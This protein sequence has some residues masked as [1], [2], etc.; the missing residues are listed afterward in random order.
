M[1]PNT[2]KYLL[3]VERVCVWKVCKA[4][5][6]GLEV[7]AKVAKAGRGH[8]D[9]WVLIR[10][11]IVRAPLVSRKG[12]ILLFRGLWDLYRQTGR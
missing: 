11:K 12:A 9:F 10:R 7:A 1:L 4:C 2:G 5:V 6:E 8:I 3:F